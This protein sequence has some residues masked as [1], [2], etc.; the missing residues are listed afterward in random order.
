MLSPVPVETSLWSKAEVIKLTRRIGA[1][2]ANLE[3]ESGRVYAHA[4]A[5]YMIFR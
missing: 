5:T 4:T 1:S 3:D 2:Q